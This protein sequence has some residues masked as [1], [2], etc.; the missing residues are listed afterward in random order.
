MFFIVCQS[1]VSGFYLPFHSFPLTLST[2]KSQSN[3]RY[4][5]TCSHGLEPLLS[6]EII[7]LGGTRETT[8][9]NA[10][11]FQGG[12]ETGYAACLWSRFASRVFLNIADFPCHSE[13]DLYTF[14]LNFDW[15]SHMNQ[16]TTF[17]VGVSLGETEITHSRYA[18]F[19]VK[20]GL[21]DFFKQTTGDRPTVEATRP[22]IRYHVH[23]DNGKGFL[24]IDLSGESL[25]RRG[26]RA[27]AGEAPLKENLAAAI[28]ALSGFSNSTSVD[29]IFLDPMCGSATL[30]IEAAMI[31]GDIAPGLSRSY[32]GF[33]GWQQHDKA[34]WSSLIDKAIV[35]EEDKSDKR[36]P[37]IIGYDGDQ[38]IVAVAR[39]NIRR[40]GL[41]N[42]IQVRQAELHWLQ[43][44]G[45]KGYLVTNPPY[46]ERLLEKHEAAGLY[47]FLGSRLTERFSGWKFGVLLSNPDLG[48]K[49][50]LK[51]ADKY[52]L[53]NGPLPCRLHCGIVPTPDARSPFSWQISSQQL[54]G[55]RAPLANRL[56]KNLKKLLRWAEREQVHCFRIYDRDLPDFNFT[57]DC[58]D[59][60]IFV[61][62][63]RAA[64][65]V[66]PKRAD[67]RFQQALSTLRDLFGV[68]RS[69]ILIKRAHS[70]FGKKSSNNRKKPVRKMTETQGDNCRFLVDF[71]HHK[72]T[73]LL[74]HLRDIHKQIYKL[75][76][77]KRF[78]HLYSSSGAATIQAVAGSSITTTTVSP[79]FESIEWCRRNLAVNGFSNSCHPTVHAEPLKW[80]KKDK[81]TYDLI[82]VSPQVSLL[83]FK[84]SRLLNLQQTHSILIPLCMKRLAPQ[85]TL[86]FCTDMKKFKL[87]T[88]L[89]NRFMVSDISRR[90]LPEDCRRNPAI[91]KCWELKLK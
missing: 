9:R 66:D 11:Q 2:M 76:K 5:A 60:L 33:F 35:R 62:E 82:L 1:P 86:I 21:V 17:S 18:L 58:Y 25:H 40:A 59:R 88:E 46:G 22:D 90:T 19:R 47:S 12:L 32:F 67:E 61:R 70:H 28:V 78:L 31:Y 39:K 89:T 14:S 49:L 63:Y 27:E 43:K 87:D 30:L 77:G 71:N 75:S 8:S 79:S 13:D 85:G 36:W 91:H 15:A 83:S 51:A 50:G 55:E 3:Y 7:S 72:T 24:N 48:E 80:L 52:R 81:N 41:E 53:Y 26:Y 37:K 10:V 38:E 68:G 69:R 57:I 23:I 84:E 44:P 65:N 16:H 4:T 73:G 54:D 29:E 45:D 56:R 42:R 20:D 74:F 64:K 34:L 6:D